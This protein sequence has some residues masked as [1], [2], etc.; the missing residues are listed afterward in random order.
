MVKTVFQRYLHV[1]IR[2]YYCLL[3]T[4]LRV[5]DA[6]GG[7]VAAKSRAHPSDLIQLARLT[8]LK[9]L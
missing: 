4:L 3:P 8:Q 2:L 5:K 6:G 7:S 1:D 9:I